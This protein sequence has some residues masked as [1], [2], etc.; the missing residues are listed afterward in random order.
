MPLGIIKGRKLIQYVG[1]CRSNSTCITKWEFSWRSTYVCSDKNKLWIDSMLDSINS[2]NFSELNW[3][4][5][6]KD[7]CISLSVVLS[8]LYQCIMGIGLILSLLWLQRFQS[9]F[10][11]YPGENEILISIHSFQKFTWLCLKNTAQLS[12][13]F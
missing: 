6:A 10:V 13:S 2:I 9:G 3:Q 1:W 12:M 7:L 11:K 8:D 4:K 5:P